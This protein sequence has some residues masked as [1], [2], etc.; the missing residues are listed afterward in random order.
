MHTVLN[1]NGDLNINE[2]IHMYYLDLL[3]IVMIS[4]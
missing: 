2:K 4:R 1:Q 3:S